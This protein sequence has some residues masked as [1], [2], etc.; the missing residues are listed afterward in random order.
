MRGE[1]LSGE[2]SSYTQKKRF[3]PMVIFGL[4]VTLL[5]HGGGIAAFFIYQHAQAS[6]APPPPQEYI[7]AKLVRLGEK[8]E[9]H[10][11]PDK[12]VPIKSEIKEKGVSYDADPNVVPPK[13]KKKPKDRD[14][15]ITNR[16]KSSF[17]KAS[18]FSKVQ[19]G[20]RKEEGDPNGTRGGTAR[21][22]SAG[23]LYM[24][25]IAD[26]W[27][28]AWSAPSII[29]R[30]ELKKLYVL[31]VVRIDA[32][33]K[34]QYPIKITRKS[35]N[36]HFDGSIVTAWNQIKQLPLPP[37]DRLAAVLANGLRLKLTWKGMR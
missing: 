13:K 28:R 33:G 24:T 35:G 36:S 14:A 18:A 21:R 9:K 7:V 12:V 20:D 27:L 29:P 8:K 4:G 31:V 34:I 15:A 6:V 22:G 37:G 23:D 30:N 1:K 19:D 2:F 26:I 10:K 3:E 5:L 17:D 32:S 16:F 25:R 11:L